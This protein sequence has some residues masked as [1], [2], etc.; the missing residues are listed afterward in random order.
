[1]TVTINTDAT[2]QHILNIGI[3]AYWIQC[4]QGRIHDS[5]VFKDEVISPQHAECKAICN[6][7]FVV[8]NSEFSDVTK[9]IVNS[10][11]KTIF[12]K[13]NGTGHGCYGTV[14]KL[15]K[16]I[17]KKYNRKVKVKFCH[18]KA[19]T[20]KCDQLSLI[21]KWCDKEAKRQLKI[22]KKQYEKV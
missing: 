1:M 12:S 21:N 19:H 5:G 9:I 22:I 14:G 10:D 17:N 3:Y 6:A 16:Q 13:M 8:L 15:R 11:C 20:D 18:V 2:H 4:D 7:L